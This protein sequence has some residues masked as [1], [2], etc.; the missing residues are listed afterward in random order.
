MMRSEGTKPSGQPIRYRFPFLLADAEVWYW[1]AMLLATCL[2]LHSLFA[3]GPAW[4]ESD[5]FAKLQAQLAFAANFLSGSSNLGFRSLPNDSAY[6]GVGSVL[7][8]YALSYL[9]DVV[10]LKLPIHSYVHSYSVFLH[11]LTFLCMIVAVVFT[12]RLVNL[13]TGNRDLGIFAGLTLLLTPFWIGYGF[14]DYKDVPVATGVIAA[15]YFAVAYYEDGL[16]R[17]SL[18]FFLALFFIGIQKLAAIPL[19]LPACIL[20]VIAVLRSP[21]VRR[22]TLISS[23]AA[24]CLFLLYL[25]TPPAWPAPADFAIASLVYS[26]Q[27]KWGGCTLTAGQ[28][29]G[30]EAD[31]GEGYSVFKYLGLWYGVKLPLLV[32]AGLIGSLLFYFRLFRQLRAEHHLLAVAL[33]WPIAALG[34]RN[35]TLYDG[36]RHVLFLMPLAVTVIFVFIPTT[37]WL[38]LRWVLA[39]YFSFLVVDSVKLQPYQYVWFNEAGRFFATEKSFETDYWGYSLREAT[40]LARNERGTADWIVSQPGGGNPNHLVGVFAQERFAQ[41]AGSVPPGATYYA[42]SVTRMNRQPPEYCSKVD[43]VTRKELFA[44]APLRLSFVAKCKRDAR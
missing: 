29:I 20:I 25:A 18:C 10:W 3:A 1:A 27:H 36:V 40:S 14:I 21:S 16:P 22:L 37:V 30:R 28:C 7:I 33:C 9:V 43:Y 2:F 6:Y 19:A 38:R 24:L 26:S 13:V 44:P 17:T 42:V 32:W 23:Q 8:P 34:L 39:I 15:T 12:R 41:D 11:T 31:N 4:D 35:S 5:E